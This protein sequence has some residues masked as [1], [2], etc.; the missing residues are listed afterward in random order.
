MQ[1]WNSGL[2][3]I[4]RAFRS[5][6]YAIYVSGNSVSL[7]GTWMHR[8]A[9]GWLAWELTGSTTWLGI[10]AF[11]DLF[12]M[13]LVTPVAGTLID[14]LNRMSVTMVSQSLMLV[15]AVILAIL[16]VTG[17]ITI[18][19]LL[20][21]TLC[22][23][24]I[25]AVNQPARLSMIPSLVDRED[26]NAAVRVNSIIFNL[27]RFI[28]PLV[29][30]LLIAH[31]GV[32]AAFA[33]NAVSTAVFLVALSQIRLPTQPVR[34]APTTGVFGQIL[35]GL[36]YAFSHRE[37]ATV[38]TLLA[39]ASVFGRSVVELMPGFAGAVFGG[40]PQALSAMTAAIGV[41]AVV[42]GLTV[43]GGESA[44]MTIMFTGTFALA[45]STILVAVM[46]EFWMV[47][48]ALAVF[49]AALARTGIAAQTLVQLQVEDAWRGRVLSI[50]G[51]LFRGA[52]AV[53]ALIMGTASEYCGLRVS[54]FAG[55]V[56]LLLLCLWAA[57]ARRRSGSE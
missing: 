40:G 6:N 20:L 4:A 28:G 12:P 24:A 46:P 39:A 15:Q 51:V 25:A 18:W 43:G 44:L 47:L 56:T 19:L 1:P 10:I 29:A 3:P 57:A 55:G 26:V 23:G 48:G 11:A 37:I 27:A 50:Y 21:L 35:E 49:G 42:G 32:A 41:G 36:R 30:G 33:L 17:S 7:I 38:L 14:R 13:V 8:L 16:V 22:L 52:P 34:A 9:N 5:R 45:G 54:V 53:G 31:S 2:A